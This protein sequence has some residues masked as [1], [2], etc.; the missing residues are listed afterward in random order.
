MVWAYVIG[1]F[2]MGMLSISFAMA[3]VKRTYN[4][5]NRNNL[6][7]DQGERVAFIIVNFLF[8]W[9]SIPGHIIYNHATNLGKDLNK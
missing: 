6:R 9:I 8:W 7:N 1:Y 2:I 5:A 3:C 4:E